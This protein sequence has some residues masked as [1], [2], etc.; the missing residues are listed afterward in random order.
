MRDAVRLPQRRALHQDRGGA[1]RRDLPHLPRR[2]IW[3]RSTSAG[4]RGVDGAVVGH[5]DVVEAVRF[6]D[7]HLAG[8]HAR[9]QVEL[10]HHRHDRIVRVGAAVTVGKVEHAVGDVAAERLVEHE[11]RGHVAALLARV[12]DADPARRVH[13]AV[14][15]DERDPGVVGLDVLR[16]AAVGHDDDAPAGVVGAALGRVDRAVDL[17]VRR[18][19]VERPVRRRSDRHAEPVADREGLRPGG[20]RRLLGARGAAGEVNHQRERAGRQRQ[21]SCH[22]GSPCRGGSLVGRGFPPSLKLWRTHPSLG[23]GGSPAD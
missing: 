2:G 1:G 19:R 16:H 3:R 11:R 23:V 15:V 13:R 14:V 10:S 20:R 8:R 22:V 4:L 9:L 17:D 18:H 7:P 6:L 5:F 21:S 12:L